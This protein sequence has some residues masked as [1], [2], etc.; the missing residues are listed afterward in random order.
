M[1]MAG[2]KGTRMPNILTGFTPECEKPNDPRNAIV[3]NMSHAAADATTIRPVARVLGRVRVPG[4]KSISHRYAMLAAMAD[5]V[6]AIQGYLTGADCLATLNCLRALGV[7]IDQSADGLVRVTGRGLSGLQASPHAL[8]AANSGTS[9]R[10]LAGIVAAHPFRTILDGDASLARRP[11]KRVITPLTQMGAAIASRDGRPPLIIDGARLH[12]I[13]Y[14]PEVP[15]AQVKSAILLAGL[16]ADGETTVIEPVGTR[17]HTERAFRA[18]GVDV[19]TGNGEIKVRGGQRL[20]ARDLVVPGDISSAAFWIAL[21]GGLPG[22]DVEIEGVGLNPS[23]T[24]ILDVVRRA[25]LRVD[26]ESNDETAGEPAGRIRVG[27]GSPGSFEI[28]PADVPGLIDEIPALAALGAMLPEGAT[29]SVRGAAEL[30]VKESDRISSL[31]EGFR[32]LGADVEEFPDGF[33]LRA[34]PLKGGTV[35][36]AGDHRLAM[37]FAL[38]ATRAAAPTTI[39]GASSVNVSYPGFFTALESLSR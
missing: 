30:R 21:A 10:L 1:G 15:S 14:Q 3:R 33:T 25:G 35:D 24:A 7:A 39:V 34:R 31:A 20:R 9:M 16:Q 4:D 2:F 23:R 13:R 38:A 27:Y 11:M 6:S 26:V 29:M 36:A 32:A 17:D 12:G 19:T 8:D 18:F 28:T 5:G 22:S 37:A